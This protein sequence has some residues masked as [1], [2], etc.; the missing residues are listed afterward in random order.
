MEHFRGGIRTQD[1][2]MIKAAFFDLDGTLLSHTAHF[3]PQSARDSLDRLKSKAIKTYLCTGRHAVE[4]DLLPVGDISFDGYITLNGHL[5]L[6]QNKQK[7]FGIPFPEETT[8]ALID[9]F[10]ERKLPLV[11]VGESGLKINIVNDAVIR[12]Q[13]A[14]STPI[15]DVAPYNGEEIYQATTF[16][17]REDEDLLRAVIPSNCHTARWNDWGVDLVLD[18]GGKAAGI[19]MVLER[20]GILPEECAAF[21]DAENDIEML[22]YCGTGIA[23][24]N[25]PDKVKEIADY[26]TSDVDHDGVENALSFFG[27]I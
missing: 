16:A 15:P 22:K 13:K 27:V 9:I 8:R 5:C 12:A 21:G 26:V 4:L 20:E 23:M 18:G 25:A 7:M 10:K 17:A 2:R 19:R 3:V 14:I 6:D 1:S 11:L 24:G